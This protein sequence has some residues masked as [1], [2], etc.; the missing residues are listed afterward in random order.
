MGTWQS[1]GSSSPP[2]WTLVTPQPGQGPSQSVVTNLPPP[3]ATF[4]IRLL[5]DIMSISPGPSP[6][7]LYSSQCNVWKASQL[8]KCGRKSELFLVIYNKIWKLHSFFLLNI[9]DL[10]CNVGTFIKVFFN[11]IFS[12]SDNCVAGCHVLLSLPASQ[13]RLVSRMLGT[14]PFIVRLVMIYNKSL[15]D[16]FCRLPHC[17]CEAGRLIKQIQHQRRRWCVFWVQVRNVCEGK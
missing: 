9:C 14:L 7:Y 17:Q 2:A 11:T 8:A 1:A 6:T 3:V 16:L 5:T 13:P 10:F 12:K 4:N 15:P